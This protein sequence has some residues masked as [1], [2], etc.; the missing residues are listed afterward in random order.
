ME[1]G[2]SHHTARRSGNP[3]QVPHDRDGDHANQEDRRVLDRSPKPWASPGSRRGST[4]T[5]WTNRASHSLNRMAHDDPLQARRNRKRPRADVGRPLIRLRLRRRPCLKSW[6]SRTR[7]PAS[8]RPPWPRQA[9]H[10][11]ASRPAS[12]SCTPSS[13]SARSGS[14]ASSRS[15]GQARAAE[16]PEPPPSP[17]RPSRSSS[18][19]SSTGR[20]NHSNSRRHTTSCSSRSHTSSGSSRRRTSTGSSRN[21]SH[22][23]IRHKYCQTSGRRK[24]RRTRRF[25]RPGRRATRRPADQTSD[26]DR[27]ARKK[28]GDYI[29]RQVGDSPVHS[30]TGG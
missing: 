10:A 30:A 1:G 5:S 18:R 28:A 21:R 4:G 8:R 26:R 9:H 20:G 16:A 12:T 24:A 11:P 13:P 22:D 3:R 2:G 29:L 6:W 17:S 23:R 19:S 14:G 7:R 15:S 25:G 27:K